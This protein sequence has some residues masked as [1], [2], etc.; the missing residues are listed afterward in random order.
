MRRGASDETTREVQPG[1][2][3]EAG[4]GDLIRLDQH[5]RFRASFGMRRLRELAGLSKR[6]FSATLR[7]A[8][9]VPFS[10]RM[11]DQWESGAAIPP[12]S[13]RV[14][15]EQIAFDAAETNGAGESSSALVL[16]D[17]IWSAPADRRWDPDTWA[18]DVERATGYL[19]RQQ[20]GRAA[21]LLDR[22][23]TQLRPARVDAPVLRLRA[24]SLALVGDAQR[25]QGRLIGPHSATQS[26]GQALRIFR[27][28]DAPRKVAQTELSLTV[29]SEMTGNL[30]L[31]ARRYGSLAVD[32]RLSPRDR[33]RAT[34]W[35]GT[36]LSKDGQQ[37]AAL[38]SMM[39]AADKFERLDEPDDWSVAHQKLALS[40]RGAGQ[41]DTALDN[42]EQARSLGLDTAPL[43][44]VR[45]DTA[46][47]HCLLTDPATRTDG[48]ET[49]A[50]ATS[51]ASRY[52]LAHQLRS[53]ETIRTQFELLEDGS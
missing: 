51:L 47:A 50:R 31:A 27:Y 25:D 33:A 23:L 53:I 12:S 21:A 8:C 40:Y 49:L 22:W 19:G 11:Y 52:G 4:A 18:E 14:E 9:P 41:L 35:V 20:F 45:Q 15:A 32:E 28:L 30:H 3:E 10:S 34:L 42:I 44:R 39:D 26:Y 38:R 24:R 2:A 1:L 6:D 16:P 43:Q 48:F 7:A 46:F 5:G 37:D 17:P 36:A 13:V 29:I